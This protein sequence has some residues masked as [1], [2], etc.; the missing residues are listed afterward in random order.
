MPWKIVNLDYDCDEPH[1][2]L[3]DPMRPI[4]LRSFFGA[5]GIVEILIGSDDVRL[6]RVRA[7]VSPDLVT[8]D[9]I[10]F[11]V[12]D[13]GIVDSILASLDVEAESRREAMCWTNGR[14]PD[15]DGFCEG[16]VAGFDI[17]EGWPRDLDDD[18]L[19]EALHDSGRVPTFRRE[20]LIREAGRRGI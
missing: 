14:K 12:E 18:A 4:H 15:Q 17:A 19:L 13:L 11:S 8:F 2:H 20:L 7:T 10:E 9:A 3:K 6:C 5:A 1:L 16:N